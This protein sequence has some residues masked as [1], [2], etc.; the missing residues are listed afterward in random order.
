MLKHETKSEEEI[1]AALHMLFTLLV[2]C[3][4]VDE[5]FILESEARY[6]VNRLRKIIKLKNE[7]E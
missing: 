2:Y 3:G 1:Q 5:D 4:D 6:V 7:G